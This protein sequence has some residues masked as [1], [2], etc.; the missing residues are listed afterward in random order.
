M[1]FDVFFMWVC[2]DFDL[3]PQL[4]WHYWHL[5]FFQSKLNK[6]S[7]VFSEAEHLRFYLGQSVPTNF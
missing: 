5:K 4:K 6:A 7:D 2:S 3:L 1:Y